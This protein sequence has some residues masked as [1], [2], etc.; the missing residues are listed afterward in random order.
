MPFPS[1]SVSPCF[2]CDFVRSWC[3]PSALAVLY[4]LDRY[5]G[6]LGRALH[7]LHTYIASRAVALTNLATHT[8]H[9]AVF[10]AD[11]ELRI[12][13]TPCGRC[14]NGRRSINIVGRRGASSY[15]LGHR[16]PWRR[17][18]CQGGATRLDMQWYSWSL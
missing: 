10:S 11:T 7:S 17:D 12:I 16:R 13:L 4:A 15:S 9:A 2:V 5:C 6:G 1:S 14:D 8:V 18:C 3:G